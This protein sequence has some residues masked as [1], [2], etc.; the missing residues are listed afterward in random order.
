MS[1]KSEKYLKEN[2]FF[3]NPKTNKI[4]NCKLCQICKNKCKQSYRV[5]MLSCAKFQKKEN[6]KK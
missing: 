3:I 5:I 1:K 2:Q 6:K 4:Q